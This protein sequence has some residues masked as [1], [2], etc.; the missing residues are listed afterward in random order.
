MLKISIPEEETSDPILV[1]PHEQETEKGVENKSQVI[2]KGS[3]GIVI[4]PPAECLDKKE[5]NKTY[6]S[7]KFIMKLFKQTDKA[8]HELKIA[9]YIRS[10]LSNSRHLNRFVLVKDEKCLTPK[11]YKDRIGLYSDFSGRN[12]TETLLTDDLT[13]QDIIDII[14]Q[15][16]DT[17]SIMHLCRVIHNDIATKNILVHYVSTPT[18]KTARQIVT[19]LADF[20]EAEIY[21]P[22][23]Y[24]KWKQN[25]GDVS[26][27]SKSQKIN[28]N[29]DLDSFATK[30]LESLKNYCVSK[31]YTSLAK[32]LDFTI[33]SIK[34]TIDE[35]S[36]RDLLKGL[37]QH[38]K[39]MKF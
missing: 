16:T 23:I 26:L 2:G 6:R 11:D 32:P 24:M 22:E 39:K 28:F 3:S 36:N 17:I 19:K 7:N 4:R 9:K 34:K 27:L 29:N 31:H 33:S 37:I 35:K 5:L 15:L 14:V 1:T 25:P 10:C 30:V 18:L 20:G 21:N 13:H 8:E 38:L 12:L